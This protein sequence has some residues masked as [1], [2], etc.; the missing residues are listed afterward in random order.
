MKLETAPRPEHYQGQ[1]EGQYQD[2]NHVYDGEV[3]DAQ[4]RPYGA[5]TS[6]TFQQPDIQDVGSD[7]PIS[8]PAPRILTQKDAQ[9]R[10]S[11]VGVVAKSPSGERSAEY[12][13]QERDVPRI[14]Q[15]SSK[16]ENRVERMGESLKN[17]FIVGAVGRAVKNLRE[18]REKSDKKRSLWD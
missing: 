11:G 12:L 14:T 10:I 13:P 2:H 3:L 5:Q 4:P 6:E 15:A 7:A 18:T 17:N 1:P 9:S 16:W 8:Q